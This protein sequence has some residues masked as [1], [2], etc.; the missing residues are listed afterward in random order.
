MRDTE[1]YKRKEHY[2]I[3]VN[4][5]GWLSG[6]PYSEIVGIGN[7]K[8]LV[9]FNDYAQILDAYLQVK[10]MERGYKTSFAEWKDEA[11]IFLP[12]LRKIDEAYSVG[13]IVGFAKY[14]REL[15]NVVA[16]Q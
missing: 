13:D 14:F 2:V 5:Y 6:K 3:G 1:E 16:C 15:A 9:D 4:G 7:A 11:R 12:I 8:V 10:S